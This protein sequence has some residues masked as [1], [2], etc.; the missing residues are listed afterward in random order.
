MKVT[1][2]QIKR[3]VLVRLNPGDDI[4]LALRKAVKDEQIHNGLIME[5]VGSVISHHYHVVSSSVNPPEEIYTKASAPAD[6]VNINGMVLEDRV[7]AHITFSNDKVAY[8]GHLE[9][10]VIVLTFSA[11]VIAEIEADLANY[12]RIGNIEDFA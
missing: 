1:S 11:I 6:I 12:D 5:G 4:L 2:S 3:L 7:H 9:E 10:G 8:G